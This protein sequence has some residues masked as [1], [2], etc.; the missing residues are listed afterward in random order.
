MSCPVCGESDPKLYKHWV[1]NEHLEPEEKHCDFC[2]FA[3]IEPQDEEQAIKTAM[4]A[5]Q[6]TPDWIDE[7]LEALV[8]LKNKLP[9]LLKRIKEG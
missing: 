2:G 1:D 3:W 5:I 8:E 6:D 9:E 7:Q 4:E